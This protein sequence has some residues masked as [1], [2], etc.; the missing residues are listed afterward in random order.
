MLAH[1]PSD[2]VRQLLELRLQG[3]RASTRK[4]DALFAGVDR[5][6]RLRGTLRFHASSTGRWSGARFQPQNLKK[7]ETKD[8]DAAIEAILAGDMK[9]VRELGAPLTVAGD[10]SRGIVCAAAGHALVGADFSAI[11]SRVLAWLAGEEW[12]LDFYRRYD[13]TGNP[14]FEPYCVMASQA[15]KRTVT[16]ED[17]SGRSFGKTCDLAFG[18]G[19]GVGAWRKF[20]PS[21]TYSDSEIEHFK[22]AFRK[23][24]QATVRFWHALERAAHRCV[25]TETQI[26]LGNRFSFTMENGTLFMRLPSG[27]RLAYP[28]AS[29]G[30]GKFEYTCELRY[31]DNAKGGWN[32]RSAWYGVLVENAV[33]AT[34][35]D[36]LAAAMQRVEA[37]GYPIVL[38]V[39]DEI[40]C[41]VPEG[42]GSVEE[43]H[44]LMTELPNWAAGLPIAAKAWTRQRYVKSTAPGKTPNSRHLGIANGEDCSMAP[45]LTSPRRKHPIDTPPLADLV[46]QPLID[47]KICCPFHDDGTPSFHIYSDHF[48]CFGCGAH[49]D[50]IDWL[51]MVEGLDRDAA[52]E[53]LAN[54]QD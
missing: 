29:L 12:K 41:E 19:G 15:L 14:A 7:P 27:R 3:A 9:R 49:G 21:G 4:F 54:W 39:H 42:F 38:T 33:Q 46:N 16:P 24:H 31:K 45:R 50:A 40:V 36:L 20:D 28:E 13:E 6:H 35:R 34:A 52:I 2:N 44:R 17:E 30:P 48:H 37:A 11:E 23:T 51:M 25:H 22:S 8:L 26:P 47:G 5:D 18:F 32:T 43:F 10:I 1:A 53:V